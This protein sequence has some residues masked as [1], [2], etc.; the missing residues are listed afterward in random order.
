MTNNPLIYFVENP[1]QT[2]HINNLYFVHS[3][4]LV[5]H[6]L[7]AGISIAGIDCEKEAPS[8]SFAL[9]VERHQHHL[10]YAFL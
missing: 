6:F 3:G 4:I 1:A 9:T 8:F 5:K 7:R 2:K 10:F